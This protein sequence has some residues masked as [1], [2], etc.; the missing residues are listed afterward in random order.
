M[1]TKTVNNTI[2]PPKSAKN[3]M[4]LRLSLSGRD[5]D[6]L[7]DDVDRRG[8]LELDDGPGCTQMLTLGPDLHILGSVH[9]HRTLPAAAPTLASFRDT[10]G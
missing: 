4:R 6:S 10:R 8:R 5:N 7:R 1:P 3:G 2:R 9:V